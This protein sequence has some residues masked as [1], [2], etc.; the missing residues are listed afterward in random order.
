[1]SP[2][3]PLCLIQ[4]YTCTISATCGTLQITG[5]LSWIFCFFCLSSVLVK[6][7]DGCP[8]SNTPVTQITQ[9]VQ[10]TFQPS[11]TEHLQFYVLP[12]LQPS[13]IF[14]LPWLRTHIPVIGE[15]KSPRPKN[16]KDDAL[17]RQSMVPERTESP[18]LIVP[19]LLIVSPLNWD[20][21]CDIAQEMWNCTIP[22]G[23]PV[24]RTNVPEFLRGRVI[25]WAHTLPAT[26]HPG[27]SRT[28]SVISRK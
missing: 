11:H 6:A 9:P 28:V 21:D 25:E 24:D 10:I 12:H 16:G 17:S 7:L 20:V 13:I 3:A 23:C 8:V 4:C 22:Q 19:P 26:R 2:N 14:C 18:N 27:I 15:K 5:V 1:M